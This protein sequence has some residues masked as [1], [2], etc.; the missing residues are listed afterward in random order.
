[1]ARADVALVERGL[2]PSRSA[3]QRLIAD[4]AVFLEPARRVERPSQRIE[5]CDRI[6]VESSDE[7]RFVSR[8]GAKLA[9]ALHDT[10]VDPSG[11]VVLDLGMS[12]G[13]FADCLLQSGAS[14]VVGIEVG[15]GQLHA[16]LRGDPRVA[17]VERLN[18]REATPARLAAEVPDLPP[19]GFGMA[20]ADL[21]FISLVK[22]L[23]AI[24]ALLA[25][26]AVVLLLVKPQFELSA[27][28]LDGRGVVAR[29]ADRLT[30]AEGVAR[31]CAALGWTVIGLHD[32][33][34]PGGDGNHEF[35]LHARTAAARAAAATPNECRNPT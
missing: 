12:T 19:E 21:S 26:S 18:V 20:V 11:R 33:A 34:L 5:P 32:S 1:L 13:G 15:H 23:P 4:G 17:C 10:G 14:R 2:A 30:A 27:S 24:D 29:P 35:F 8:A 16:R 7:T 28:A 22:V 9:H 25:P 31:A 6:R 3:A